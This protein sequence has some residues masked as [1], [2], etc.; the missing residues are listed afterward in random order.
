MAVGNEVR[1]LGTQ[2]ARA[3]AAIG[4]SLKEAA[5][6][7]GVTA[8]ELGR[9]ENNESEPSVD[10]L[11][12]LAAQYG[13]PTDYF[14]K[15]VSPRPASVHFRVTEAPSLREFSLETRQTLARF[16]ELCRYEA[17]L[18]HLAERDVE[19]LL[20]RHKTSDGEAL[21]LEVRKELS[22]GADPITDIR[23]TLER[24]GVR[25]FSLPIPDSRIA[26]VSWWHKDYGPCL[27]VNVG[28]HPN[29]RTF[30]LAHEI[31]HLA[32]TTE[33]NVC[34]LDESNPAERAANEFAAGFLIPAWDLADYVES[35]PPSKGIDWDYLRRAGSR[36][37]VSAEAL[38]IR[39]EALGLIPNGT[40]ARLRQSMPPQFRPRR[41]RV[42]KWK[43][44]LGERYVSAAYSAY[45]REAISLGRLARYLGVDIRAASAAIERR[46]LT[47]RWA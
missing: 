27:L 24:S 6:L 25:V 41:G 2:L 10:N 31:G 19:V 21:A 18:E 28:D 43:R 37:H 36:Y 5:D 34:D 30:T 22:L 9:W 42:P 13:R 29:R 45:Q 39:A 35:H 47:T 3:R 44:Q 16:E 1:V 15:D 26:G 46:D 4:L 38:G 8:V 17:D 23:R 12:R 33:G 7:A 11:W 40:M 32:R 14:L 20:R